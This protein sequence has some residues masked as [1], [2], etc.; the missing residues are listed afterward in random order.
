MILC[1]EAWHTIPNTQQVLNQFH[2]LLVAEGELIIA[3]GF[4][5]DK[6]K[7][8]EAEFKKK[9]SIEEKTDITY[10]VRNA[11]YLSAERQNRIAAHGLNNNDAL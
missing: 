8:Y 11:R 1:I 9:F 5:V 4:S 3:D 6:I 7:D 2:E 10:N